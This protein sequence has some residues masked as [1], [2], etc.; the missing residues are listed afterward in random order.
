MKAEAA[1]AADS[2]KVEIPPPKSSTINMWDQL[3]S[4]IKTAAAHA[5]KLGANLAKVSFRAM[6]KG[7]SSVVTGLK[8]LASHSRGATN[9]TNALVKSIFSLKNMLLT[10][11][12]STFISGIINS[13][14]DGLKY[15]A[16]YSDS[17]NRAM[18]NMTNASARLS[19]P[20]TGSR[21]AAA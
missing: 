10:R 1:A 5:L 4:A 20:A 14:K 21:R 11:I 7:I 16:V 17:F 18:S 15:L 6:A 12:K 9:Q 13:A 8:N 19:A 3:K 2:G